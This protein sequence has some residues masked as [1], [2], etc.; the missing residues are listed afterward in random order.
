MDHSEGGHP[1][2]YISAEKYP[3]PSE[4]AVIDDRK[5]QKEYR[6][7]Q[8]N[9][10][11]WICHAYSILSISNSKDSKYKSQLVSSTMAFE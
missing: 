8:I 6:N 4:T 5:P 2:L 3:S 11:K 7:H 10:S 1:I 9:F